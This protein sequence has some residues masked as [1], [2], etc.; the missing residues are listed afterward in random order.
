LDDLTFEAATVASVPEPSTRN[1]FA[2][3]FGLLVFGRFTAL[4][5]ARKVVRASYVAVR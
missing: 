5:N 2:A 4:A 1:L 3:A